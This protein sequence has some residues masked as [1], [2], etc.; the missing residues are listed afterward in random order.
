MNRLRLTIATLLTVLVIL[1]SAYAATDEAKHTI[2]PKTLEITGKH[3][4]TPTSI[5]YT[6][7]HTITPSSYNA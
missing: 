4:I 6:A 7:K 1:T 5:E 2:T 3:T